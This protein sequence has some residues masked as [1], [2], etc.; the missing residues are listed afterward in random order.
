MRVGVSF[1]CEIAPEE[2]PA[3]AREVEQLGYDELW[4]IEDCF[5]AAGIS[6][7]ATALAVTT[8]LSVG[9]GIL[10]AV[11]RN[12]ATAAMELAGLTR[13]FA[14]RVLPGFGHGVA[15][16]MRQIG[17]FPSSQLAALG[18]TVE[19][20]RALLRGETVSRRGRHVDLDDVKLAHP[21]R[22]VPPVSLGVRGPKS[23]RLSGQVADGTVLAELATPAYVRWAREQIDRG[24]T[25]AGRNEPHRL[26]V[27]A[28]LGVGDDGRQQ[29]RRLIASALRGG[30]GFRLDDNDLAGRVRTLVADAADD[31]TLADAL[32]DEYVDAVAVVG[33][34]QQCALA[35]RA[36]HDAGADTVVLL[37]PKRADDARTQVSRAARDVL[38][39]LR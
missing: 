7:A 11:M 8:E 12:P 3:Y 15:E 5:Y 2:L 22:V 28:W 10:P 13:M 29:V 37:P 38:P 39:H 31:D 17:A 20:V 9:L 6:T 24:R 16:W 23:L 34:P 1:P 4:V 36:L 18:E 35:A 19:V 26:T 27:Y 14:G 25:E 33:S 30:A 32:P 21:P